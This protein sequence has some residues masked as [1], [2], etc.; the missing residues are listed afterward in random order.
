[1]LEGINVFSSQ[2]PIT[3][4]RPPADAKGGEG[5]KGIKWEERNLGQHGSISQTSVLGEV[6]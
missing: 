3:K 6:F 4:I 5:R 1:M 2:V